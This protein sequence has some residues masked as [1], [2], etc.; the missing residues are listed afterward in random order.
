MHHQPTSLGR[1]HLP[2]LGWALL[3]AFLL[4][5]YGMSTYWIFSDDPIF[6]SLRSL[7]VMTFH[8]AIA[9]FLWIC[10][11]WLSPLLQRCYPR[12]IGPRLF[13]GMLCV[14]AGVVLIN[15]GVY[16]HLFPIVMGR[17]VRPAGQ[18]DV[19]IRA[20][21]VT[22]FVYGWLLM[23]DF[24]NGQAAQALHLQQETDALATDLDRSELAMLEA[25]IEPHFLF[26]TLAHV[27]RLYRIDEGAADH[28]LS[29]LIEYLQRALPALR[30][31]DWSIGDEI[32]LIKL[33]LALIE[34]RFGSR[35]AFA[36][37]VEAGC[38]EMHIPAL[39][40]AT[41]VENAVKHGLGPKAGAGSVSVQVTRDQDMVAIT[42]QDD[43]V[44]LRQASGHGLGLATV[45]ARVR[46]AFG[47]RASVVI[48][49]RASGGVRAAITILSRAVNV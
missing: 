47:T 7:L 48:E 41:L 12:S 35:M 11:I 26:N 9:L 27:K 43:G 10:I 14:F 36:I 32:E 18:F 20:L 33:Y 40:V 49:P 42:V 31:A 1:L 37:V 39:T 25:Q 5:F 3:C 46:A 45:R 2:A 4:H 17:D 15:I 6:F 24:S 23:R 44:G 38:A 30:R 22:E 8:V 34:Q 13:F 21:M 16:L 29:N 19:A 28:V